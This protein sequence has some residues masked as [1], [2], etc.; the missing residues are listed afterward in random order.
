MAEETMKKTILS[1]ALLLLT[2]GLMQLLPCDVSL[3]TAPAV[4]GSKNKI[5]VKLFV[6][7]VHRRCPLAIDQTRLETSGLAIERQGQWQEIGAGLYRLDLTVSLTG[8]GNGE[9]RV[10]RECVKHGLQQESLEI[11]RP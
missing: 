6:E 11:A 4:A 5:L 3:E 8:K 7:C 2:G 9:I 10:L 1:I